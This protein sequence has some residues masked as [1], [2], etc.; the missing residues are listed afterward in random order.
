MTAT[1]SKYVHTEEDHNLGDPSQLVPLFYAMFSPRSV[2][3]VG[4]GVGNFL[5][6]F[7]QL[8]VENVLGMDGEW[9]QT[10]LLNRY[11]TAGEFNAVDFETTLPSPPEKFDLCLSLEV[12]E[13]IAEERSDNFVNLLVQ[14][15]D[16]IIFSAALPFQGGINHVNEQKEEY[17]ERKFAKHGFIKYDIIRHRI[18]YNKKISGAYRRNIVVYSKTD[19]S[20][21]EAK[22]FA[23]A[24][25]Q[26]N[27]MQ[28]LYVDVVSGS[29][30]VGKLAKFLL[31]VVAV[32]AV[33]KNLRRLLK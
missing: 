22:D 28:R 8:G 33:G 1:P 14:T 4:C 5:Y 12:A 10:P 25:L 19:A 11:L 18:F 2:C 9:A 23:A 30:P 32:K 3:D 13:H 15:A 27:C 20:R 16:T 31:K 17:W 24:A 21:F 26:E 6:V 7:K 29:L